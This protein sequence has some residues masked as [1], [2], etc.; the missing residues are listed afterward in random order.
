MEL[1]DQEL[2]RITEVAATLQINRSVTIGRLVIFK[3]PI[4]RAFCYDSQRN[5]HF[6]KR[7]F[8]NVWLRPKMI[9]SPALPTQEA[10]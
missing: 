10:E 9:P 5:K 4:G 3:H 2:Q 6:Y 7:L 1:S 8:W